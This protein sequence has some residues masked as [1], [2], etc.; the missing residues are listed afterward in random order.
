MPPLIDA[1]YVPHAALIRPRVSGKS[2]NRWPVAS[3][4]RVCNRRRGRTLPALAAAK[5]RL[6]GPINDMH[7]DTVRD[8]IEAQNGV[9]RPI[10]AGDPRVVET[11]AFVKR[12]ACRLE[13]CAFDLVDQTVGIDRLAAVDCGDRTHQPDAAGIP[14]RLQLQPQLR[15]RP[16]GSYNAQNAKPWPCPGCRRDEG[17][18]PKISDAFVTTS[19]ARTS[20]R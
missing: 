7:L 2:R 18:Q 5:E 3:G 8:G 9:G 17:R 13:D 11:H 16:Q 19:R 12:P 20:S 10:D 4:D 15:N 14:G 1:A 6:S